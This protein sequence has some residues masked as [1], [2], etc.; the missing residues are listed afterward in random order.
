MYIRMHTYITSTCRC[1]H[2]F[3]CSNDIVV[4]ASDG[5]WDNVWVSDILKRL[6]KDAPAQ[7]MATRCMS[8]G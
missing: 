6:S 5:L 1:S 8:R 3:F 2:V 4:M 7:S